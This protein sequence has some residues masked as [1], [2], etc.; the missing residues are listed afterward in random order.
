MSIENDDIE[1]LTRQDTAHKLP[2]V[3]VLLFVGLIVWGIYYYIAYT[4]SIG[5][6]TQDKEITESLDALNIR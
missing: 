3:W 1:S 2:I 5:G 4:P 6:W